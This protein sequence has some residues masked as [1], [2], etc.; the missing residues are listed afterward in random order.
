MPVRFTSVLLLAATVARASVKPASQSHAH[1]ERLSTRWYHEE[2]HPVYSLFRRAGSN[3]GVAYAAIG[4]PG[5][6]CFEFLLFNIN[7][8]AG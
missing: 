5:M 6:L 7:T 3:D 4:T 1:G 8:P 2:D